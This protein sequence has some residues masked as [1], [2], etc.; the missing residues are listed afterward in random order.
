MLRDGQLFAK[1]GL[2]EDHPLTT[3]FGAALSRMRAAV[4]E[5]DRHV[6]SLRLEIA[7]LERR[8]GMLD[9]RVIEKLLE[10]EALL[11]GDRRY[12]EATDVGKEALD[13]VSAASGPK[14]LATAGQMTSLAWTAYLGTFR[15]SGYSLAQQAADILR[16]L[17]Q[18]SDRDGWLRL[19]MQ[20]QALHARLMDDDFALQ[21]LEEALKST[22]PPEADAPVGQRPALTP[23][24]P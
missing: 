9:S 13:R 2:G 16:T 19:A 7:N 6:L 4:Y 10:L 5:G 21:R 24:A 23:S 1:S 14:S 22:S 3:Q 20:L 17:P 12:D 18:S 15:E 11:K 8:V